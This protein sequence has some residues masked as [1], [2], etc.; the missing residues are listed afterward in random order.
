MW[1]NLLCRLSFMPPLPSSLL[2]L[3]CLASTALVAECLF[4]VLAGCERLNHL[5]YPT[6]MEEWGRK[7][8]KR[9]NQE[10][11]FNSYYYHHHH[12]CMFLLQKW[13]RL[14]IICKCLGKDLLPV[15]YQRCFYYIYLSCHHVSALFWGGC[16]AYTKRNYSLLL[17]QRTAFQKSK[18]ESTAGRL[19]VKSV[20]MAGF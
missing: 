17:Y 13:K 15:F 18:A 4:Q 9:R 2:L 14:F 12:Y 11:G 16:V 10:E 8:K 6:H 20:K 19:L 3:I 1:L 7:R 5:M